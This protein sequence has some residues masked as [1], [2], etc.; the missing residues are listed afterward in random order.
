[1]KR[2]FLDATCWVAAA[3]S[4]SGGSSAI[5]LLAQAFLL[6]LVTSRAVLQ[7]AER[8]IQNKMGTS[9]LQRFYSLLNMTEI[10]ICEQTTLEE[11]QQWTAL[12]ADK[13]RHVL[14]AAFKT[15]ADVLV[16]LDRKHLLTESV[17]ASFSIPVQDTKEFL[18]EFRT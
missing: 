16:T 7:E 2:V 11:E 10:E 15:K 1:M 13:D 3:G 14:A 17:Q 8:N 4:E 9:A 5:F 6:S 12:T 18:T